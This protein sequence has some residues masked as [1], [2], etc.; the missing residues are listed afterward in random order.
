MS[1]NDDEKNY[2]ADDYGDCH[3]NYGH[4]D[5]KISDDNDGNNYD[6]DDNGNGHGNDD[7]G[8]H[9]NHA[10][11]DVNINGN[12]V[13]KNVNGIRICSRYHTFYLPEYTFDAS[14]E[15]RWSGQSGGNQL[16]L[17]IGTKFDNP[18]HIHCVSFLDLGNDEF[19]RVEA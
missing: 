6:A 7:H 17:W 19:I 14:M 18:M 9:N 13:N 10:Y 16:G 4:D 5:H 1:D 2:D 3:I 11:Y 12:I 15:S 8:D